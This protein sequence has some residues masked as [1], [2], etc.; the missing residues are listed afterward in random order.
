MAA[1][2]GVAM[3]V[4]SARYRVAFEE[5]LR[6]LGL[7]PVEESRWV[8]EP[9]TCFVV[10]PV[11]DAVGWEGIIEEVV[12]EAWKY[13]RT[14]VPQLMARR[15]GAV[16]LC[17]FTSDLDGRTFECDVAMRSACAA[18]RGLTR[19]LANELGPSG[20]RVNLVEIG[21][22]S[23]VKDA[24]QAVGW[25]V[26]AR[27]ARVTGTSLYVGDRREKQMSP[28]MNV[29]SDAQRSL[30]IPFS[31]TM[32]RCTGLVGGHRPGVEP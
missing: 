23:T 12:T 4:K 5:E 19:T 6:D 26:S 11:E 20:V 24:A 1:P 7:A 27:S 2:P 18:L 16:V 22:G 10:G 32:F 15:S 14:V 9:V 8:S 29:A 3:H 25:L 21:S 13:C 31:E 30:T 17:A 28:P